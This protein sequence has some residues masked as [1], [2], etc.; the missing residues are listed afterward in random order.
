MSNESMDMEWME[1]IFSVSD[2]VKQQDLKTG[3]RGK[4][5]RLWIDNQEDS[6]ATDRSRRYR[7]TGVA[8]ED[9]VRFR[10]VE[11]KSQGYIHEKVPST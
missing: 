2:E 9:K 1:W 6:G 8:D 10:L 11:L 4:G 7:S 3:Y 5:K